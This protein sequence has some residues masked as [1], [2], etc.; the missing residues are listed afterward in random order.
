MIALANNYRCLII[1]LLFKALLVVAL[2]CGAEDID[3]VELRWN[4][5]LK[6]ADV[7]INNGIQLNKESGTRSLDLRFQV[8]GF[9]SYK[10]GAFD[11]VN[12]SLVSYGQ[13]VWF[14]THLIYPLGE[15][16]SDELKQKLGAYS[17]KASLTAIQA[18]NAT[19]II[20]HE[21]KV[22]DGEHLSP[23]YFL[24]NGVNAKKEYI[25]E[26]EKRI[27]TLNSARQVEDP[28]HYL[29]A[30]ENFRKQALEDIVN[31]QLECFEVDE[32]GTSRTAVSISGSNNIKVYLLK[33]CEYAHLFE[34][35]FISDILVDPY[36]RLS[37]FNYGDNR[38][39][40]SLSV[41][42]DNEGNETSSR[43]TGRY[44]SF[45][46]LRE[47]IR[48]N[49]IKAGVKSDKLGGAKYVISNENSYIFFNIPEQFIFSEFDV[50]FTQLPTNK[51]VEL[52]PSGQVFSLNDWTNQENQEETI[53]KEINF[54]NN[55]SGTG[56]Q[57]TLSNVIN[58]SGIPFDFIELNEFFS[59][60]KSYQESRDGVKV[61]RQE[62]K[63]ILFLGVEGA[64]KGSNS[65][66]DQAFVDNYPN[67]DNAIK[68]WLSF[69]STTGEWIL[70]SGGDVS[71]LNALFSML[72]GEKGPVNYSNMA[73]FM[74]ELNGFAQGLFIRNAQMYA[75]ALYF[76]SDW[77]TKGLN[78]LYFPDSWWNCDSPHYTASAEVASYIIEFIASKSGIYF[79]L[80]VVSEYLLNN[81]DFF[82]T[83]AAFQFNSG[84]LRL[85]P[86]MVGLWHGVLDLLRA[87]PD[88][89]RSITGAITGN[90]PR[91]FNQ[92]KLLWT[93]N[94]FKSFFEQMLSICKEQL[95]T[96]FNPNTPCVF[97]AS[98]G[99][100][101]LDVLT[102]VFTLGGSAALK[103]GSLV[104]KF[105]K[106]IDRLD[107]V[108]NVIGRL[109]GIALKPV[110]KAVNGV[111]R[112]SV[113][114]ARNGK[115]I[116]EAVFD[117]VAE[118]I[119]KFFDG[120]SS[121]FE[122]AGFTANNPMVQVSGFGRVRIQ[123][124]ESGELTKSLDK[125]R[126]SIVNH[127]EYQG[128]K[129]RNSLQRAVLAVVTV[130]DESK[131]QKEVYCLLEE[132]VDVITTRKNALFKQI[133]VK[134]WPQSQSDAL[135][136]DLD[137]PSLLDAFE[138]KPELV[139]AWEVLGESVD[140]RKN[141]DAL[142]IIEY[143]TKN[144][145][146]NIDELADAFKTASNKE[147]WFSG[148]IAEIRSKARNL[149]G[150]SKGNGFVIE[151]QWMRGT[152]ANI[153]LFPKQ[154][155]DK[156]K[157]RQFQ[158]F[159]E[160][161]S[162]FWKAVADDPSLF[163]QFGRTSKAEMLKG[164]APFALESQQVGGRI[165]YEIHHKTPIHDGG[166]VYDIDNMVIVTPRYHKEILDPA[167][168][169]KL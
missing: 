33:N 63:M 28:L 80:K 17:L 152:D 109:T 144:V 168:H 14:V 91:V 166:E 147:D 27:Q 39:D 65:F 133:N 77:A 82:T 78:Y 153:G 18:E 26:F 13:N 134:D 35:P 110:L 88:I 59:G 12:Q 132:T 73:H 41:K 139:G 100:I 126:L 86:F 81:E 105:V 136:G 67:P 68:V 7:S 49:D 40:V 84:V 10:S 149:P 104:A 54:S 94:S 76:L 117:E 150:T 2:T 125:A 48:S 102:A 36:L 38:F 1:G 66:I 124:L 98:A 50:D 6:W 8:Q 114:I 5:Y 46:L 161:R 99:T 20:I 47:I 3:S 120:P 70:K 93:E 127:L 121:S 29:F 11:A 25:S 72:P 37:S 106:L 87:V 75:Q 92:L 154:I 142:E 141:F 62:S 140:L 74:Q 61:T 52:V 24:T 42:I 129:I 163:E 43:V 96:Q 118:P 89:V 58:R 51:K 143:Y 101:A 115:D 122:F 151:G 138:K 157:G 145:N 156:L 116:F 23:Y 135:W 45:N 169:F 158:N 95:T 165:K 34:G 79:I 112:I 71:W 111:A 83:V 123:L 167:Y 155:A 55:Q 85:L 164:N 131:T 32:S 9:E 69:N 90:D 119:F 137:E 159:D 16:N 103:A 19:A 162:E 60:R 160:F 22:M 128:K 15:E 57:T 4:K 108:G 31:N 97:S 107:V 130:V 30:F 53:C 56:N 146:S 21:W 113:I 64:L 148:I 44:I